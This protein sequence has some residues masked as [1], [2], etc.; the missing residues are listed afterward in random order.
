MLGICAGVFFWRR[1][2]APGQRPESPTQVDW[3]QARQ[4]YESH[5]LIA[6]REHI[7]RCLAVWPAHAEAHFLMARVSRQMDD[8]AAWQRHL[9]YAEKLFW[10]AE[11]LTLERML[12]QAQSGDVWTVENRLRGLLEAWHPEQLAITDALTKGYLNAQ[13]PSEALALTDFWIARYPRD[14]RPHY[15]RGC[16]FERAR[17][18]DKAVAA[19]QRV[20]ELQPEFVMTRLWLGAA[21]MHNRQYDDALLALEKYLNETPNDSAALLARANCQLSLGQDAR[22]RA[23][24]DR[25]A[26]ILADDAASCMIRAKLELN[27]RAPQEALPW[28]EKADRLAPHKLDVTHT[29][30]LVYRELRQDAKAA[31]CNRRVEEIRRQSKQ[32]EALKKQIREQP[33]NPATRFEAGTI[34]LW[35]GLDEEAGLW[36]SSVLR[37]EPG[38]QAAHQFLAEHY[39]KLGATERA[40]HHR[41]KASGGT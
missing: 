30:A 41:R 1:A 22:V 32:L 23:T 26:T 38:H 13:M 10:P 16:V 3:R 27:A 39:R 24:L 40:E 35:L 21:L 25:R 7:N 11:D 34:S 12:A 8:M 6:A 2:N 37:L 14:W 5:D 15:Y 18:F 29:L 20:L 17:V 33:D 9:E 28:L 19:Y 36:L 4:S 31:E